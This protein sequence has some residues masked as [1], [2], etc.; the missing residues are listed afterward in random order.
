MSS[1]WQVLVMNQ[2][3][4]HIAI[5]TWYMALDKKKKSS[6]GMNVLKKINPPN[7]S[8]EMSVRTKVVEHIE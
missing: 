6:S 5:F 1:V 7:Y 2:S 3:I 4:D 8:W